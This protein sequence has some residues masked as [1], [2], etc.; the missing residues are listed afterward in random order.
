MANLKNQLKEL[1]KQLEELSKAPEHL[2]QS[3]RAWRQNVLRRLLVRARALQGQLKNHEGDY[4][5]AVAR[6]QYEE[7][8]R[9]AYP[10][11]FWDDY[12]RLK[13]GNLAGLESA[14]KFLEA[15]PWFYRSGYV[16]A[17]LLRFINRVDLPK[18]ALPRLR[19]IVLNAVNSRD[20]RE[21]RKYCNL[22]KRIDGPEFQEC[23]IKLL[24]DE[25]PAVRRRAAWVI[26]TLR[27][28]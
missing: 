20:R 7:A 28:S 16:K 3:Y 1:R 10:D 21:F 26:E 25:D 22:A 19:K 24:E 15:D 12:K 23:L 6:R 13:E 2:D 27:H 5:F 14:M 11:R 4:V 8:T 9:G 17:D 18:S